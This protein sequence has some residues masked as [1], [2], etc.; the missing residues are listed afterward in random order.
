MAKP[1]T[2]T[3]STDRGWLAARVEE[4]NRQ[5]EQLTGIRFYR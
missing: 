3:E 4:E 1:T 5:M 2:E